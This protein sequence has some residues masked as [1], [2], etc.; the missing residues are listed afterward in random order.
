MFD[1]SASVTLLRRLV[2][3]E[4]P[5][6]DPAAC[7][8]AMS[9]LEPLLRE[10]GGDVR[11]VESGRHPLLRADFPGP[12]APEL[13][14]GHIDTVWPHGTLDVRSWMQQGERVG[15]PGVYDMKAGLVVMVEALRRAPVRRR[16]VRVLVT[17]DEEIGSRDSEPALREAAAGCRCVLGFEPGHP[18]GA[19]KSGRIGNRRIR[20]SATGIAAHAGLDP[21]AGVSAIDE[22]VDA[23]LAVRRFAADV[24]DRTPGQLLTNIGSLSA[25]GA[26]NVVSAT[27]EAR[28]ELRTRTRETEIETEHFLAGLRP[29]RARA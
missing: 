11:L 8:A 26:T 27:A 12:G 7:R 25:P 6:T 1:S 28:L 24:E 17:S 2:D 29:Q 21:D 9:E 3:R 16:A 15:A 19:L 4:T 22:L 5:S 23:L 20:L 14:L 18:D 10:A 13:W